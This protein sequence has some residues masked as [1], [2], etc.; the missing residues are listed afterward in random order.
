MEAVAGGLLPSRDSMIQKGHPL[1]T[2][3]SAETRAGASGTG[4]LFF[5]GSSSRPGQ[6]PLELESD[7]DCP[8]SPGGCGILGHNHPEGQGRSLRNSG[9]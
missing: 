3:R 9:Q 4:S 5:L 1:N 8:P 6:V 7:W 2:T